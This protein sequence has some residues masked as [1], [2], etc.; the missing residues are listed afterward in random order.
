MVYP[1]GVIGASTF[2]DHQI[3]VSSTFYF[4]ASQADAIN[5]WSGRHISIEHRAI[6][7][8]GEAEKALDVGLRNRSMIYTNLPN[9]YI[10]VENDHVFPASETDSYSEEVELT[11]EGELEG[12]NYYLETYYDY[13]SSTTTGAIFNLNVQQSYR[14]GEY[15]TVSGTSKMISNTHWGTAKTNSISPVPTQ[16]NNLHSF[17]D[18]NITYFEE[19]EFTSIDELNQYIEQKNAAYLQSNSG[20]TPASDPVVGILT[21]SEPISMNDLSNLLNL[22]GADLILYQAKFYND[23]GDWCTVFSNNTNESDMIVD[24]N[25]AA[26]SF[27]HPHTSYEGIVCAEISFDGSSS[28]YYTLSQSD[29]VYFLD[30][31]SSQGT[32]VSKSYAWELAEL[33]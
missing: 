26:E 27:G 12:G 16:E 31:S 2:N 22:S 28:A 9:P 14:L 6:H 1:S 4:S 25:R 13:D 5:N 24:A 3:R 20:H 29:L 17:S 23:S 8:S 33:S 15:Q 21:F 10:D 32:G 19:E 11:V 18:S 30:M 7:E